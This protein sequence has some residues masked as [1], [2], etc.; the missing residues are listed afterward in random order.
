M[1]QGYSCAG[2]KH[3]QMSLLNKF[4]RCQG[5]GSVLVSSDR[6]ALMLEHRAIRDCMD[7]GGCMGSQDRKKEL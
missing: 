4:V 1:L 7:S 5:D 6:G 3:S 2:R